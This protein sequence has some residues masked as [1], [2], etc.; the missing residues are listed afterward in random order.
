MSSP[1]ASCRSRSTWTTPGSLKAIISSCIGNISAKKPEQSH[2]LS[3]FPVMIRPRTWAQGAQQGRDEL[4]TLLVVRGG[5][6]HRRSCSALSLADRLPGGKSEISSLKKKGIKIAAA[7][8]LRTPLLIPTLWPGQLQE[9]S[10]AVYHNSCFCLSYLVQSKQVKFIARAA[11]D[12]QQDLCKPCGELSISVHTAQPPNHHSLLLPGTLSVPFLDG[13]VQPP[14]PKKSHS[15]SPCPSL[16]HSLLLPSLASTQS[17]GDKPAPSRLRGAQ[18]PGR[19]GAPA[20][21]CP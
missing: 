1:A 14:S 21:C 9:T 13:A 17:P 16:S 18:C 10:L 6:Q 5:C 20:A 11:R 8:N 15:T 12:F 4:Q 19:L 2:S 3:V 7:S